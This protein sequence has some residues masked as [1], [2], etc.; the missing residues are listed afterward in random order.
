M[1]S[2]VTPV[3]T[4]V[5]WTRIGGEAQKL[6]TLVRSRAS[7]VLT[8][9]EEYR[10]SGLAGVSLLDDV[11]T[12]GTAF[13]EYPVTERMPVMPRLRALVPGDNPRNLQRAHYL[14][15][16]Q[17]ES[18]RPPPPGLDTEWKLLLM[19]GH[20][21]VGHVDVFKDDRQALSWY[22]QYGQAGSSATDMSRGGLWRFLREQVLDEYVD[23][24]TADM[25]DVLGPTPSVGGMIPKLLVSMHPDL[26]DETCF[27]PGAAGKT[28]VLL[29]VEPPEYPGLLV[30]EALCLE[31]HAKGGFEVPRWKRFERDGLRFLVVER[32]DRLP[33][34]EVMPMESLFS[35]IA[36][37][38]H[39]VQ[40]MGDV[41]LE[42]LGGILT[43]LGRVVGLAENT[44]REIYGRF[45]MAYLTGNGDLH[46]ENLSLLGDKRQCRLA[47]VYDP[48]PMRAW[49]RHDLISAIPYDA[50]RYASEADVFMVL[51]RS[52]GLSTQEVDETVEHALNVSRNFA[53]QVEDCTEAGEKQRQRLVRIVRE[54]RDRMK[55]AKRQ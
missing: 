24:L 29:K 19:G 28:D 31:L 45:L 9:E 55:K 46:L 11:A 51:G 17:R 10:D 38:N 43:L 47:P 14:K 53:E 13:F 4:A 15:V 52:L 12:E 18:G 41:M 50:A 22:E 36:T 40:G 49:A 39:R 33:G 48:A 25:L 35:V 2:P 5:I 30:L 7:M 44:A 26:A 42:D 54:A 20:G 32:F 16:L 27:V 3:H 8:Y 37:G 6:G 34:G 1:S 23:L 21:G